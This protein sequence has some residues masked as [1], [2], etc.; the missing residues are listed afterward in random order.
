MIILDIDHRLNPAVLHFGGQAS[1]D[2][3]IGQHV[4]AALERAG[5]DLIDADIGR[6]VHA[7]VRILRQR[8]RGGGGQRDQR[9][10][11]NPETSHERGSP[12]A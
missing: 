5:H 12:L 11:A 10:A 6:D 4:A 9:C 3:G 7:A 1:G 2:I 8:G